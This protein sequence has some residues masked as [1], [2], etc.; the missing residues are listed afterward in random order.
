MARKEKYTKE[1]LT[2]LW[3]EFQ[4]WGEQNASQKSKLKP[5]CES[6]GLTY[7]SIYSGFVKHKI[8]SPKTRTV[9]QTATVA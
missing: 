5:F 2:S 9:K 8:L 6:K 1:Y 4:T 3:T 7:I